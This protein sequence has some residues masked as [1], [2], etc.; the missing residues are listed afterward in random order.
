[1]TIEAGETTGAEGRTEAA[2]KIKEEE[3]TGVV[4]RK[5]GITR[6]RKSP[7]RRSIGTGADRGPGFVKILLSSNPLGTPLLFI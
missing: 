4:V 2:G 1:V 7:C 6:T 5:R 3:K